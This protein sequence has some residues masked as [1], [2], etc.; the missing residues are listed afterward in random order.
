MRHRTD[1]LGPR[2]YC[3]TMP[4]PAI[5]LALASA[6]ALEASAWLALEGH[7]PGD[8]EHDPK[9]WDAWRSALHAALKVSDESMARAT[10]A[11]REQNGR[12]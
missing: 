10:R 9:A 7:I 6:Y 12:T 11:R 8:P 1:E 5:K 3:R 2:D 4:T